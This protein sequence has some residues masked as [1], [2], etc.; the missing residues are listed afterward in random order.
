MPKTGSTK[1]QD[2]RGYWRIKVRGKWLYE[3]RVLME[4]K[5]RRR[6]SYNENVHH[7]NEDKSD[8][9][10][11]NLVLVSRGEHAKEHGKARGRNLM[12]RP[13][14][15]CGKE[16]WRYPSLLKKNRRVM[17][18]MECLYKNQSEKYAKNIH[19]QSVGLKMEE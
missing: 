7:K 12:M 4:R 9:R 17:C 14:A 2:K 15:Q 8:N 18:S 5:L 11:S 3:H 16:V 10:L 1:Y 6:L 13:C 19:V